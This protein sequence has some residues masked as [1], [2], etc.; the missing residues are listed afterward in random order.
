MKGY[1]RM[2]HGI[3]YFLHLSNVI[4]GARIS[5]VPLILIG[6]NVPI[7]G[8]LFPA[9]WGLCGLAILISVIT[10]AIKPPSHESVKKIVDKHKS[11]FEQSVIEKGRNI[12]NAGYSVICGYAFGK[13][14]KLKRLNGDKWIFDNLVLI[15]VIKSP[16]GLILY[17]EK[18]SLLKQNDVSHFLYDKLVPADI[19]IALEVYSEDYNL[20]KLTINCKCNLITTYVVNDYH[21]RDFRA[22][23]NG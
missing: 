10:I 1:N 22:L 16:D 4:W 13:T 12:K 23:I 5:I 11:E 18:I 19:N 7:M 21:L 3:L 2:K 17:G 20:Y 14:L 6:I 15:S 8:A 9:V